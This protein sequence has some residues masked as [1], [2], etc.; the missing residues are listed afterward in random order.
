MTEKQSRQLYDL[1]QRF[2]TTSPQA[3]QFADRNAFRHTARVFFH[4]RR[5]YAGR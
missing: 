4:N 5:G 2:G 3:L 1:A